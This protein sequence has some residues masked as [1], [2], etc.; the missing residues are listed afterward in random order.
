MA[1]IIL[2]PVLTFG[3]TTTPSNSFKNSVD[4]KN[5]I[6]SEKQWLLKHKFQG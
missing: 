6:P 5:V 3:V 2:A 1:I 4:M